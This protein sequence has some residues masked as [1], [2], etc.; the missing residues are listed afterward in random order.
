MTI[1]ILRELVDECWKK[2]ADKNVWSPYKREKLTA[3]PDNLDKVQE[4]DKHAVG[5]Y[6]KND[7]GSKELVGHAPVEFSSLLYHFLYASAENY[8]NVEVIGKR[9][10]L[11]WTCRSSQIQCF[12]KEQKDSNGIGWRTCWAQKTLQILFRAEASVE[13]FL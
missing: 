11:G 3:Q 9:K 1:K 10:M 2:N 7:A 5:I 8:I 13:K 12:Y 6:K 4:N